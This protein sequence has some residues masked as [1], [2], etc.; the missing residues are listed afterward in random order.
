MCHCVHLKVFFHFAVLHSISVAFQHFLF[1]PVQIFAQVDFLCRLMSFPFFLSGWH[2]VAIAAVGVFCWHC[3]ALR[4]FS[5]SN[6]VSSSQQQKSYERYSQVADKV[7]AAEALQC[8]FHEINRIVEMRIS[9]VLLCQWCK[10]AEKWSPTATR[11]HGQ[12]KRK[13][14]C[15]NVT[16][17][18]RMS[19]REI[20]TLNNNYVKWMR[21]EMDRKKSVDDSKWK[22][23]M[24]TN[25]HANENWTI[26]YVV[27]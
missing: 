9:R 8:L 3:I 16:I 17:A 13:N 22:E 18:L 23:H 26:V 11:L 5:R 20:Y 19:K 24:N 25:K 4:F 10:C 2:R 15:A 12:I 6:A 14:E 27:C 21:S 7:T 1:L